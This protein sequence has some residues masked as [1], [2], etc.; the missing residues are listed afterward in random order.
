MRKGKLTA[1]HAMARVNKLAIHVAGA[2]I[3]L[4]N[5]VIMIN[6]ANRLDMKIIIKAVVPV[7]QA[8]E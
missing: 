3:S 2:E 5:A 6:S 4:N 1:L 7:F 8:A